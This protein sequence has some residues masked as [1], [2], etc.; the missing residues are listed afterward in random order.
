V[1]PETLEVLREVTKD[2]KWHISWI[3]GKLY[4]LADAEGDRAR[5]DAALEKYREIDRQVYG[6]L[7]EKERETFGG[8]L[9][10]E[11]AN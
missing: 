1:D 10:Q 4:E 3:K 2:E 11:I 9:A 5:A 8:Q 7:L 6:A